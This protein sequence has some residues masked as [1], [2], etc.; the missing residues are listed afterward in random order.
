MKTSIPPHCLQRWD[1]LAPSLKLAS[2]NTS[3]APSPQGAEWVG[4][5]RCGT[6]RLPIPNKTTEA[7]HS[8]P[9]KPETVF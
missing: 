1:H 6:L 4:L 2:V 5:W 8:S 7:T 9:L 3:L